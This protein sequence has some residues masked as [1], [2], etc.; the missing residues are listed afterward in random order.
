MHTVVYISAGLTKSRF[1]P[2][3]V[4]SLFSVTFGSAV[5]L[6]ASTRRCHIISQQMIEEKFSLCLPPSSRVSSS[7][8]KAAAEQRMIY[9]RF[10]WM[11]PLKKKKKAG[12]PT[13]LPVTQQWPAVFVRTLATVCGWQCGEL[14]PFREMS[15]RWAGGVKSKCLPA[16]NC[17]NR[18]RW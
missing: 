15:L 12:T 4:S 3:G 14:P 10:G 16:R 6:P 11:F 9:V 2:K 5:P 17:K 18:C 7:S 13:H 1:L 8:R